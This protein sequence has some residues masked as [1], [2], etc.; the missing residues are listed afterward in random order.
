MC[1]FPLSPL[2]AR[3]PLKLFHRPIY[4]CGT[5]L[6]SVFLGPRRLFVCQFFLVLLVHPPNQSRTFPILSPSFVALVKSLLAPFY[7]PTLLCSTPL[8]R[9][10]AACV[11]ALCLFCLCIYEQ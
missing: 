5:I 6:P 2:C 4:A 10:G 1:F 8:S 9:G 11:R 3:Q 7:F